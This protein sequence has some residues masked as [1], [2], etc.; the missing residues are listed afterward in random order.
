VDKVRQLLSA[1]LRAYQNGP[2]TLDARRRIVRDYL[3]SIPLAASRDHGEVIGLGD[4]LWVWYEADFTVVNRLLMDSE[5]D[6]WPS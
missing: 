5:H 4:G 6:R 3:N 1:S 2:E